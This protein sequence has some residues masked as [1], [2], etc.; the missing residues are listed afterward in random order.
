MLP[1]MAMH[2]A[3]LR[4]S[5]ALNVGMPTM[6]VTSLSGFMQLALEVSLRLK[7]KP[8]RLDVVLA[9]CIRAP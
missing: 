8:V 5:L 2:W 6:S 9:S 7:M 3:G 4:A 1:V